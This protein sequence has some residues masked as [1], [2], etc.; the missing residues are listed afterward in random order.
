MYENRPKMRTLA[1]LSSVRSKTKFVSKIKGLQCQPYQQTVLW[2]SSIVSLRRLETFPLS[3]LLVPD[4][5]LSKEGYRVL[6]CG[7]YLCFYRVEEAFI[8]HV[9]HSAVNY[10]VQLRSLSSKKTEEYG[11]ERTSVWLSTNQSYSGMMVKASITII[12]RTPPR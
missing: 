9:T 6:V 1:S 5:E 4:T 3:A 11:Q 12:M 2:K 7:R 10:P 8:Y